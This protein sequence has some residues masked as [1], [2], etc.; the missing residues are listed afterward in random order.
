MITL[1]T[2]IV[3]LFSTLIHEISHGSVA[4]ALGD[5]TAKE[6]GRLTLNP[7]KH[8]DPFGTVILP[9]LLFLATSG[10]G[11]IFGWAKPVP[12]NPYNFRDR[13]WGA[14][15]VAFAGPAVNFLIGL[16]F[17]LFC[18]FFSL[19]PILLGLFSIII[20]YNF[21]WAIFNLLPVPP[22]DGSWILFRLLPPRWDGLKIFLTRYSS[23]ILLFFVFF[24]LPLVYGAAELLYLFVCG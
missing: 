3:L 18:R 23:F 5:S 12:I 21:V 6:E 9:L 16:V 22:L 13:K 10:R 8:I 19:P 14:L 24:G 1:F 17:G 11:P 15:K 2:L 7:L 4:Y 20:I